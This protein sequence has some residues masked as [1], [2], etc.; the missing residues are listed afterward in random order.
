MACCVL[1]KDLDVHCSNPED[2]NINIHRHE[3]LK[4]DI[5]P[6]KLHFGINLRQHPQA[7]SISNR[8]ACM[9]SATCWLGG[10]A[11]WE[12]MGSSSHEIFWTRIKPKSSYA[13]YTITDE[14]LSST[15]VSFIPT[16]FRT[17]LQS[18]VF[19][20]DSL[21][22]EV[23]SISPFLS[24][25]RLWPTAYCKSDICH[26]HFR[27]RVHLLELSCVTAV[28]SSYPTAV[29]LLCCLTTVQC[30]TGSCAPSRG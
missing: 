7:V 2:C 16:S 21:W 20:L 14:L 17:L 13:I 19:I 28:R 25:R 15:A 12:T 18:S 3:N 8:P 9:V 5:S 27:W 26:K 1:I 29:S 30:I 23:E 22:H 11:A 6:H 24:H 10:T 4:S